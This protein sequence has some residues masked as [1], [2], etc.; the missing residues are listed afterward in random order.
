VR[1]QS[2]FYCGGNIQRSSNLFPVEK[3]LIY[4]APRAW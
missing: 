1:K 2:C 4:H 3:R